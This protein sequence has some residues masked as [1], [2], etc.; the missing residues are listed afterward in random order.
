M[1]QFPLSISADGLHFTIL[2]IV[3]SIVDDGTD[4]PQVQSS[5]LPLHGR[6]L[7]ELE[8]S[9]ERFRE[10]EASNF[11]N[12]HPLVKRTSRHTPH[13]TYTSWTAIS[14]DGS[15]VCIVDRSCGKINNLQIFARTFQED[16]RVKY[17]MV[18][19]R[20]LWLGVPDPEDIHCARAA[21]DDRKTFQ[22]AFHP[23]TTTLIVT[24]SSHCEDKI[25]IWDIYSKL[26][27]HP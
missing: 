17:V 12:H 27:S 11:T 15:F 7:E 22:L 5:T 21:W 24:H 18:A 13:N 14:S 1:V 23:K 19:Q 10:F 9:E 20:E 16:Q 26:K 2:G 25:I 6:A 4:P 8:K 3:Y